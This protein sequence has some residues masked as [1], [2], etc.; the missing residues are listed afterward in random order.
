MSLFAQFWVVHGDNNW[1]IH[2]VPEA[3]LGNGLDNESLKPSSDW[4]LSPFYNV[5]AVY[6]P[7]VV[8]EHSWDYS[9]DNA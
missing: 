7:L 6:Q 2:R 9:V 8:S 1:S 5:T 4:Q 3:L